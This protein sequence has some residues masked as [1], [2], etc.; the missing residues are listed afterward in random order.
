MSIIKIQNA[1]VER[2][3]SD[4]KGYALVEEYTKRDGTAGKTLWT[5]WFDEPQTIPV[6][7]RGNFSG[8]YSDRIEDFDGKDGPARTIRRNINSAKID[9]TLTLPDS[10]ETEP[11]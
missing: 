5:A 1:L 7:A 8:L 11:F 2:T 9:G 4:G 3:F 6:G 10:A